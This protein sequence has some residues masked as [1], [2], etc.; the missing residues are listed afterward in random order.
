MTKSSTALKIAALGIELCD[1]KIFLHDCRVVHIGGLGSIKV[2]AVFPWGCN[3]LE[4]VDW[5]KNKIRI[6]FSILHPPVND[7]FQTVSSSLP[8]SF[9]ESQLMSVP[10]SVSAAL[11]PEF[12]S[13]NRLK[14]CETV[15]P[16]INPF[17]VLEKKEEKYVTKFFLSC[18]TSD[19]DNSRRGTNEEKP[20]PYSKKAV[21]SSLFWR[22]FRRGYYIVS[23]YFQKKNDANWKYL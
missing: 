23:M 16:T 20:V 6:V 14:K 22:D 10:H 18:T 21:S 15:S 13:F 5:I 19:N 17:S 7:P 12:F 4:E 3:C 2:L 8:Q 1:K 11:D 9:A